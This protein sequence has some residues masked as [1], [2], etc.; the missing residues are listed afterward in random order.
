MFF[1]ILRLDFLEAFRYNNMVML[2]LPVLF[3][4]LVQLLIAFVR[5]GEVKFSKKQRMV[6]WSMAVLLILFGVLRNLPW[7]SFLRPPA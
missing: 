2:L 1:S 7:F 3:V 5:T 4:L 6:V